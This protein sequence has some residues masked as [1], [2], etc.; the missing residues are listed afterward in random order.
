MSDGKINEQIIKWIRKN[1]GNDEVISNFLFD[2]LYEEVEHPGQFWWRDTY[3][4]KIKEYIKKW[5]YSDE[6]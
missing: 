2:L 4:K 5:D 3:K 6:N 1:S